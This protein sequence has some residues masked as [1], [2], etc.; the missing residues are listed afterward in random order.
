MTETTKPFY[1]PI[2]RAAH[3]EGVVVMLVTFK[4]NGEA[5]KI[6]VVNGP[7]MLQTAAS[8]YVQGWRANEFTGPR[9]CPIA[10]TFH[11]LREKDQAVPGFVRTDVQHVTLNSPTPPVL[12]S[13]SYSSQGSN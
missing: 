3:V 11:L 10:I 8:N 2:A 13:Y 1:P 7:K 9:T 6:D 4:L 12:F 5:D